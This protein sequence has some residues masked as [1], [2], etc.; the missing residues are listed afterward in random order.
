MRIRTMA[1]GLLAV[2]LLSVGCGGV[3]TAVDEQS[4]LAVRKDSLPMCDGGFYERVYYS[5]ATYTTRIGGWTCFCNN[6]YAYV[7]G[8]LLGPYIEEHELGVCSF[9]EGVELK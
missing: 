1:G 9:Q 2:G 8:S 3:D 4:N 6:P 5:D 7:H